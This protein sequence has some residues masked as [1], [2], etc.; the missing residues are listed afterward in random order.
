MLRSNEKYKN[1]GKR[2]KNNIK[3]HATAPAPSLSRFRHIVLQSIHLPQ[4][5]EQ[6][7][8]VYQAPNPL[9]VVESLRIRR[10]EPLGMQFC[11]DRE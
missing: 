11:D 2:N 4:D 9:K 1:E 7:T 8:V 6:I 3:M 10:N 5:S